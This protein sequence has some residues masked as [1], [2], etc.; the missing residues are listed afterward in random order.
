MDGL[1][2]RLSSMLLG[3]RL[4]S[5]VLH[6]LPDL[7]SNWINQALNAKMAGH[8]VRGRKFVED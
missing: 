1:L 7:G 2:V 3:A 6:H 4:T 5:Y 8:I